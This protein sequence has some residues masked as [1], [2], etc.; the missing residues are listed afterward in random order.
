MQKNFG[1]KIKKTG[2][3]RLTKRTKEGIMFTYN[4]KTERKRGRNTQKIQSVVDGSNSILWGWTARVREGS[5]QFNIIYLM[6]NPQS[7]PQASLNKNN[8][9]PV[10]TEFNIIY[11]MRTTPVSTDTEKGF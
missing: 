6:R 10:E 11:F 4:N 1:K 2:R 9:L 5:G 8:D 3:Y 7:Y